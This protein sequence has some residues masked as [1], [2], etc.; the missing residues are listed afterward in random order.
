M[1]HMCHNKS[2]CGG[3]CL[4][5]VYTAFKALKLLLQTSGG[6]LTMYNAPLIKTAPPFP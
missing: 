2:L 5:H 6:V 3:G 4:L 1:V